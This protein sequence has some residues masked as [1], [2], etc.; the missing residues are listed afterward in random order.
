MTEWRV[1]ASRLC[2][3]VGLGLASVPQQGRK[4]LPRDMLRGWVGHSKACRWHGVLRG[5]AGMEEGILPGSR[6]VH[7]EAAMEEERR[8]AYVGFTRA[9]KRLTLLHAR[10][11]T[12]WGP[13]TWYTFCLLP[14][15]RQDFRS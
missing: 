5:A 9:R 13:R 2:C 8:L 15:R 6:S 11:R 4:C 12:L 1:P 3:I 14:Q 10:K 7:D